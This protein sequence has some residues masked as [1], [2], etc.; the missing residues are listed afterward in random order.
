MKKLTGL[1]FKPVNHFIMLLK[2]PQ[3][4]LITLMLWM[5]KIMTQKYIMT[6]PWPYKWCKF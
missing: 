6:S 5:R 4:F 1:F 3:Y 2:G